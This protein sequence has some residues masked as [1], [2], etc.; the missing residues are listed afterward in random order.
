[1]SILQDAQETTASRPAPEQ[2]LPKLGLL[3]RFG[4]RLVFAYVFFYFWSLFAPGLWEPLVTWAGVHVFHADAIQELTGSG[5]TTYN[6]IM[7][8][9]CIAL[10]LAAALLWTPLDRTR[11]ADACFSEWMRV[12]VRFGLAIQMLV[13]GI[14]KVIPTQFSTP[15]LTSLAEPLGDHSP[16]GLLWAF[17]GTSAVYTVFAGSVETLGGL[18]LLSRRTTLLGA[19]VSIVAMGNVVALNFCYDVPVK[20]MSSHLLLLAVLLAAPD[21]SRLADIFL[22]NR[23]APPA[24]LRPHSIRRWVNWTL[25]GVKLL[26]FTAII[27]FGVEEDL[28][29]RNMIASSGPQSPLSGI[30]NV[31]EPAQNGLPEADRW[32]QAG[33]DSA[34]LLGL[35]TADGTFRKY[36]LSLNTRR[37]TLTLASV[38]PRVGVY[39]LAYAQTKP[40]KF[41]LHG[42]FDGYPL[43]ATLIRLPERKSPLLSRGFHWISPE[44]FNR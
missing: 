34:G 2:T 40:G 42:E 11:R 17:M 44:P 23:P 21:V 18:L 14:M 31:D 29:V 1:M 32:R 4:F 15:R 6:W 13:Y 30:W 10:A 38:P 28:D 27:Y 37:G 41:Q 26:L 24:V 3:R 19:L 43:Q 35:T 5:D 33:I 25:L 12:A 16:M 7:E 20:L 36:R 9:D 22:L 8:A 39:P